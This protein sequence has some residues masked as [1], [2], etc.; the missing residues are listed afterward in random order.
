MEAVNAL[1][2]LWNPHPSPGLSYSFPPKYLLPSRGS[3]PHTCS[4]TVSPAHQTPPSPCCSLLQTHTSPEKASHST[5]ASQVRFVWNARVCLGADCGKCPARWCYKTAQLATVLRGKAAVLNAQ[6]YFIKP[7]GKSD[8]SRYKSLSQR[9]SDTCVVAS[10]LLWPV[11]VHGDCSGGCGR[12]P[13]QPHPGT[14]TERGAGGA[15]FP[16]GAGVQLRHP[17][18]HS[19]FWP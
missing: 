8:R 4:V 16:P 2:H 17:Q 3:G 1:S 9:L 14:A 13:W 11:P 7:R 18:E 12:A 19:A 10:L 5:C 15:T 6:L